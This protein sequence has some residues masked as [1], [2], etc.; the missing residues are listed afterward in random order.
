MLATRGLVS[1]DTVA[2]RRKHFEPVHQ[3]L[4][5]YLA[6]G[7]HVAPVQVAG[8]DGRPSLLSGAGVSPPHTSVRSLRQENV[9]SGM[10]KTAR[11]QLTAHLKEIPR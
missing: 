6:I 1:R 5:I 8:V 11:A 9:Q 4:G 7:G 3:T 10:Q 2:W